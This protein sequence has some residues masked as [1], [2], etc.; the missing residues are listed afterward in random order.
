M[1]DERDRPVR[2]VGYY[3]DMTDRRNESLQNKANSEALRQLR[4]QSFQLLKMAKTD[5]LTGLHNRQAAIPK[6]E[7]RL[8]A[9]EAGELGDASCALIMLDLDSSSWPTTCSGTR[10]AI[11]LSCMWPRL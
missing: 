7:E 3:L 10:T 2:A 5:A 4:E 11:R 1:R 6:I 8:R 9:V